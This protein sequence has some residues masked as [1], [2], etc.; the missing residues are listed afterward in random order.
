MALLLGLLSL[1]GTDAALADASGG[2]FVNEDSIVIRVETP[3]TP[4]KGGE[5]KQV[6]R[7][8]SDDAASACYTSGG[9]IVPCYQFGSAWRPDLQC[10]A[11]VK[12]VQP[13]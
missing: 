6:V 4:G 2:A 10:Y 5:I 9:S 1:A 7:Q 13:P 12:P 3:G 8:N 11:R